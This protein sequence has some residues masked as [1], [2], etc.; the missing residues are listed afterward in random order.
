MER[1]SHI[2]G[3]PHNHTFD[4]VGMLVS[5]H[6][7]IVSKFSEIRSIPQPASFEADYFSRSLVLSL[8]ELDR[9]FNWCKVNG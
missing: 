2:R 6:S 4:R 1:D 7:S 3:G 5:W 8:P 9:A